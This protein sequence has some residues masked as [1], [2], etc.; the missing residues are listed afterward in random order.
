MHHH[1]EESSFD[2]FNKKFVDDALFIKTEGEYAGKWQYNSNERL[3]KK[4]VKEPSFENMTDEVKINKSFSITDILS[5]EQLSQTK[6][7]AGIGKS[8]VVGAVVAGP[9][10][11]IAAGAYAGSKNSLFLEMTLKNEM[12]LH[13]H[14]SQSV[15]EEI[16]MMT[17][18]SSSSTEFSGISSIVTPEEDHSSAMMWGFII[19]VVLGLIGFI[20]Q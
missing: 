5:V 1:D 7:L 11:A 13:G 3:F 9:L 6:N 18:S 20:G 14:A 17:R 16:L 12:K 2:K 4:E 19:V 10:G 8:A 15:Y